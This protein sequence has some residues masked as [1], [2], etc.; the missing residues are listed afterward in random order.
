M[1]LAYLTYNDQPSGVYASQVNDVVNY[2]N[3]ELDGNITLI[4][5]V[6]MRG[7][8]RHRA[9]IHAEV[10][11]AMVLP[12]IPRA[13]MYGFSSFLFR[14]ICRMKGIRGVI[15]RNVIATLIALDAKRK[16][17]VESV[18]LDGR[19]AIAAEWKEFSVVDNERMV[20]SIHDDERQA[21]IDADFRIAV[22]SQ[23]V[24]YWRNEFNYASDK[25]VVI[26]CT[27]TSN[28]EISVPD[29]SSRAAAR[30]TLGYAPDEIIIIYSGSTAGW[31]S[32]T[33]VKTLVEKWLA[34]NNKVRMLFLSPMD[35]VIEDLMNRH[36]GKVDCRWVA[37]TEVY[38]YLRLGDYGMLYRSDAV[39]NK[40]AAPTKFAEYLAAGLR[41]LISPE[42][43]DYSDFVTDKD[44]GVVIGES[45]TPELTPTGHEDRERLCRLA[46]E[47]FTKN[48]FRKD[49]KRILESLNTEY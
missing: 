36:P 11:A 8:F 41:V 9:R 5:F 10:P 32:F 30:S 46:S 19:G 34:E 26:P 40:V 14:C 48:A 20:R 44:C 47:H 4:A 39:T 6:S 37:H 18:C 29:E 43:G 1:K 16:K 28:L 38:E 35:S 23:L 33:D 27:L 25:H 2:I 21:V 31:Q 7:F 24:N 17:A 3:K 45:G 42:L 49:Y 13:S 12:M 22:S 15:S